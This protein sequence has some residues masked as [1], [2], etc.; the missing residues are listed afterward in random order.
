MKSLMNDFSLEVNVTKIDK[1][2]LLFLENPGYKETLSKF[3]HLNGVHMN[4]VDEERLL[5]IH[6]ILGVND[7]VKIRT[8]EKHRIGRIGEPI[9][10]RTRFG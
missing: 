9:A 6:L 7:Y 8:T 5:P 3:P 10:E 4:D 1:K 2:E